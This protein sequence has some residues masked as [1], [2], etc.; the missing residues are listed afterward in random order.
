MNLYLISFDDYTFETNRKVLE[1]QHI[2]I[3]GIEFLK[4]RTDLSIIGQQYGLG[5]YDPD[6]FYL[7]NKYIGNDLLK[8]RD[9]PIHVVVHIIKSTQQKKP[10]SLNDLQSIAGA[11]LF[12]NLNEIEKIRK[13]FINVDW[14]SQR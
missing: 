8:M 14:V 2:V 12:D 11:S 6:V 10:T 1:Y 13:S 5:S 9:F 7:K 4:I 3:D